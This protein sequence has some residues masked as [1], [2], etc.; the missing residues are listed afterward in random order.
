MSFVQEVFDK[1][2]G[3]S[4]DRSLPGKT[5][6]KIRLFYTFYTLVL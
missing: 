5:K 1:S 6:H 2:D 4:V 3:K